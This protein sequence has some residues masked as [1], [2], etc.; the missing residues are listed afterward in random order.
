MRLWSIHPKYLDSKGIVALWREGLLA[1]AVLNGKTNGYKNHP[2]LERFK[3][4]E[5]PSIALDT[6][7]LYVYKESVKR[8][9][10]FNKMKIG[11]QFTD[12]KID[13][14][15]GQITYEL[16]HLKNKLRSRN[17]QKYDNIKGLKKASPNPIFRVVKGNV[18]DWEVTVR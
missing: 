11:H 2:Q 12:S 10:K 14:T 13:V 1:R 6:Y 7:L 15:D 4:Q 17:K 3:K 8:G 9:Y 16:Q 5:D 18:E